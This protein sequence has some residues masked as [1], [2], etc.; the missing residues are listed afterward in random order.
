M[1]LHPQLQAAQS[2]VLVCIPLLPVLQAMLL[3]P[4]VWLALMA[5]AMVYP[6]L[7]TAPNA[8]LVC[9][10]QLWALQLWLLVK[11]VRLALTSLA[12]LQ[13]YAPYALQ[14]SSRPPLAELCA[15]C[16]PLAIIPP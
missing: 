16:V 14:V 12:P 6:Q 11:T 7:Q 9:I 3:V 13:V 10:L 4:T 5:L 15:H 1:A 8:V 2:V